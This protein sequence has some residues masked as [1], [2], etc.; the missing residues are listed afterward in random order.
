MHEQFVLFKE[1]LRRLSHSGKPLR[2]PLKPQFSIENR[3]AVHHILAIGNAIFLR[4]LRT[5][6]LS[7]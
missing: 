5:I 4:A 6:Q 3:S 2:E 7:V 1:T